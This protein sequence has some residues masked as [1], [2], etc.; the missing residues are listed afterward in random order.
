MRN[1]VDGA[2]QGTLLAAVQPARPGVLAANGPGTAPSLAQ[3]W[4]GKASGQPGPGRPSQDA[5][6]CGERADNG[7]G[8]SRRCS[9]RQRLNCLRS[10]GVTFAGSIGSPLAPWN[11]AANASRSDR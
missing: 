3:G 1:F 9:T 7:V 10:V 11:Q 4:D 8:L 2:H 6:D 5:L